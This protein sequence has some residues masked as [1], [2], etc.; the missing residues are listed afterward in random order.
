[1]DAV[2][3]IKSRLDIAD[4]ISEYLT[5]KQA[6]SGAFKAVCP[7]HQEKTP[8]FYVS[9]ARQSWHCFGCDQGGDHFTFLEKIEGMEFRE[10]LEFLAQKAGVVLPAFNQEKAGER[11]R[12]YEVN[13]LAMRFFAPR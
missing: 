12:L 7:F 9:R 4:L 2:Q 8:S 13:D 6:G 11:H 1:M 3:D 10:A 5:L